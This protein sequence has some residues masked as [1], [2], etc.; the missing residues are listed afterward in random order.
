MVIMMAIMMAF[1]RDL[2]RDLGREREICGMEL[3]V[4]HFYEIIVVRLL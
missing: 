1:E 4:C 3:C 2:E